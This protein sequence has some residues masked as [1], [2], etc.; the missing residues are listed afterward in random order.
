MAVWLV[1]GVDQQQKGRQRD[2]QGLKWVWGRQS[3]PSGGLRSRG[4]DAGMETEDKAHVPIWGRWRLAAVRR[5]L[6]SQEGG[7]SGG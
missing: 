3:K 7:E 5:G 2:Q 1:L 4:G 6:W